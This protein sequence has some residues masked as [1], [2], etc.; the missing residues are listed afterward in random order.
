MKALL[1]EEE[2]VDG[3]VRMREAGRPGP[4]ILGGREALRGEAPE[5][6]WEIQA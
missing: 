3:G 5:S 6:A 4:H 1:M 2:M